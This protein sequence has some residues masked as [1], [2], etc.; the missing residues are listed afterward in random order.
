MQDGLVFARL[1]LLQLGRE[2]LSGR[3]RG[4]LG[5]GG[6][7]GEVD[8]HEVH[9]L[10]CVFLHDLAALRGADLDLERAAAELAQVNVRARVL[11]DRWQQALLLLLLHLSEVTVHRAFA[12]QSRRRNPLLLSHRGCVAAVVDVSAA[13][14]RS[15]RAR[16]VEALFLLLPAAALGPS[17]VVL[18]ANGAGPLSK[19]LA[20]AGT[21][22]VRRVDVVLDARRSLSAVMAAREGSL[23]S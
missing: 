5:L 17:D 21:L 4:L 13:V 12:S 3:R 6:R 1:P 14:A 19:A 8:E 9:I 7:V 18:R 20:R 2:L 16:R 22:V 11:L 23:R 15:E 10:V